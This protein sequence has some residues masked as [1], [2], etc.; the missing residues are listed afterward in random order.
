MLGI[1]YGARNSL[2]FLIKHPSSVKK[3]GVKLLK[4]QFYVVNLAKIEKRYQMVADGTPKFGF[5]LHYMPVIKF[6][7]NPAAYA[8][9]TF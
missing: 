4:L 6:R 5:K 9:L 1:V 7:R 8:Y 2:W 3:L